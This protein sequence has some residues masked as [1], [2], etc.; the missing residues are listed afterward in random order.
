MPHPLRQVLISSL[1]AF[2]AAMMLCGPCLHAM[3][4]LGHRGGAKSAAAPDSIELSAARQELAD[5]CPI[6]QL[7]AQVQLPI[8]ACE[9]SSKA[10]LVGSMRDVAPVADVRSDALPSCPRGPPAMRV[11]S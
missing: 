10:L 1:I 11:P 6:C 2:H 3:P 9:V 4:G 5:D 8:E 7:V